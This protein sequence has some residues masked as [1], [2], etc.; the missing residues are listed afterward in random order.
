MRPALLYALAAAA[1][2]AVLT[3]A[4]GVPRSE[5]PQINVGGVVNAASNLPA[6]N[7]FVSPGAIISIY[8]TGLA[9]VAAAASAGSGVFSLPEVLA[10]VTVLFGPVAAPLFYVSPL[11]INAQVPTYLQPGEWQVQVKYNRLDSS[12]PVVVRPYSPG[13]FGVARHSDGTQVTRDAP[14]RPGEYILFFG[15]GF[16]PT[17]PPMETGASA[18]PGPTWMVAPIAAKIG[19]IPLAPEDIYYWGL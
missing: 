10:G 4:D 12:T 3:A 2:A 18:P 8:G 17:R 11:Q 7:N 6:P 19:D 9:G 1:A 5:A 14:A 16:G 15:T 13:L